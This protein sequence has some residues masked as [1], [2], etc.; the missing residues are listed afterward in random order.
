MRVATLAIVIGL[1]LGFAPVAMVDAGGG[2]P[3][4]NVDPDARFIVGC[5]IAP[6]NNLE[7]PRASGS[8]AYKVNLK[9]R[10]TNGSMAAA[11][12]VKANRRATSRLPL[13]WYTIESPQ[14]YGEFIGSVR[15]H[16]QCGAKQKMTTLRKN[17]SFG[18]FA[19]ANRR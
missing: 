9:V 10:L 1:G 12:C 15:V 18:E 13:Q 4:I 19:C 7:S 11:E 16:Y 14:M 8:D 5:D 17:S 3:S 6:Y 2:E